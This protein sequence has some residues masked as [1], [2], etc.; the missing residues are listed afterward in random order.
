MDP[1]KLHFQYIITHLFNL[2]WQLIRTFCIFTFML[3]CI[4][5]AKKSLLFVIPFAFALA[6]CGGSGGTPSPFIGNYSGTYTSPQAPNT[7]GNL[8]L[9]ITSSGSLTGTASDPIDGNG[10]LSGNISNSGQL[11]G[12]VKTGQGT[13]N[14][15]GTA[16]LTG[17]TLSGTI[18]ETVQGQAIQ[19]NFTVGKPL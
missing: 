16:A 8:T 2:S 12:T 19:I 6:G 5:M 4:S 7:T 9:A 1:K 14:F 18:N 13:S 17:G 3:E 15:T 10:T 11:T